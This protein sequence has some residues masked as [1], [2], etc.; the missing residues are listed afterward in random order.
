MACKK[1][2]LGDKIHLILS[3]SKNDFSVKEKDVLYRVLLEIKE[4]S[5][6]LNTPFIAIELTEERIT[7]LNFFNQVYGFPILPATSLNTLKTIDTNSQYFKVLLDAF[8]IVSN[9]DGQKNKPPSDWDLIEEEGKASL[10]HKDEVVYPFSHSWADK[11]KYFKVLWD[12]YGQKIEY[13]TLYEKGGKQY[14]AKNITSINSSIRNTMNKL[15]KEMK[16]KHLPITI[17][18][19]KGLILTIQK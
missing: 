1:Y 19:E 5:E 11:Y 9:M 6:V 12:N 18:T 4:K 10:I 16:Q 8:D 15:E 14:P 7:A 13:K 2:R 3:M 17:K